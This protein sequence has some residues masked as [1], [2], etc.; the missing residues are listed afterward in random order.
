MRDYIIIGLI[1]YLCG[2]IPFGYILVRIFKGK[3]VRQSGSGNI[4]ATNVARTAP[5][6]GLATLLLDGIKGY[7]PVK[8]VVLQGSS[9]FANDP[10]RVSVLIAVAALCVI[11]GHLFPV[12]LKF[13]GGKGVAT[14]VGVYFA[15]APRLLGLVFIVF[16]LVFLITRYV[17][18]ASISAAAAF[19][20][21]GYF[22]FGMT[23]AQPLFISMIVISLLVIARHH[24]NVHKLLNGTEDRFTRKR[25]IDALATED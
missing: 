21:L 5:L 9:F 23:L 25:P 10:R 2:S 19:P 4:G 15:L 14:A 3:D 24:S 12:W 7:L 6:L 13:R 17:S 1:S 22:A 11:L 16:L 8:Y 20:L 18:L